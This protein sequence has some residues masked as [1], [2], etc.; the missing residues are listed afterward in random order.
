MLK[1]SQ[2]TKKF[3]NVRDKDVGPPE[4]MPRTKSKYPGGKRSPHLRRFYLDL[5][6]NDVVVTS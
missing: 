1:L 6:N 4:R 2:C 5:K 3:R